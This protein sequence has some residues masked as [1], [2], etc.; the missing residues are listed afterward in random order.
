MK[1]LCMLLFTCI[2]LY[3]MAQGTRAWVKDTAGI[4]IATDSANNVYTVYYE[5]NPGGDIYLTKRNTDG[6]FLWQAKF[7][8]TDAGSFESASWV[9]TDRLGNIIVTGTS[10][11]GFSNPV[12]AASIIMKFDSNGNLLWRHV[13]ETSFDGSYTKKCLVDADNNIYVLGM[14]SGPSG[15]VT[16]VKKFSPD[17]T[18][19]WSYF[20]NA[21]I[22]APVNFKFTPD[23][24]IVI[25]CRSIFGSVNG[26]AKIDLSGNNLWSLG[27]VYSLTIGDAAGDAYGNT[28]IVHGEFVLNSG[29]VIKKL[30][31]QGVLIWDKVYSLSAFRVE[32]GS[33]NCPVICGFP[34]VGTP[35]A[36]FVK[37]DTAGNVLWTNPDADGKLG[38]LLH[39][40]L[41]MDAYNNIY[42]GAG[43]LVQMAICKVNSDGSS[44]WTT[45]T[46]GAYTNA[47]V[48]GSDYNVYVTGGGATAKLLQDSPCLTPQNLAVSNITSSGAKISW[49]IVNGALAYEIRG[50]KANSNF[51]K[52]TIV[53]GSR[54][55]Y[56]LTGLNCSTVYEWQIRTVC[57]TAEIIDGSPFSSFQNFTTLSC[58]GIARN[59]ATGENIIT[60]TGNP[61]IYPNPV[62]PGGRITVKFAGISEVHYTLYTLSGKTAISGILQSGA[63]QL[64]ANI[65]PGTYL[66]ELKSGQESAREKIVVIP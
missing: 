50:R 65:L 29:S 66:L 46:R 26:Y 3:V 38:L 61:V 6:Q 30:S 15:F 60:E 31:P 21:G 56:T 57:D 2:P 58:A 39:A 32:T 8:N 37:T 47:F 41:T 9:A 17:G 20:D 51:W 34:N 11:S 64:P 54:H 12:T 25:S 28:Y 13:Y 49:A 40:Q 59:T 44:A 42:L 63:I 35:G 33:D 52:K 14:G 1:K 62:K 24:K 7:D 43:T 19:L 18:A 53:P 22:G 23:K 5:F 4:S 27:G 45:T 10:N 16:K 55:S 36:A 48:L